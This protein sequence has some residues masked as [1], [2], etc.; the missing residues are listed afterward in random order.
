MKTKYAMVLLAMGV[1]AAAV[2]QENDDMYFNSKDRLKSN[3]AI[4]VVAAKRYQQEDVNA[5]RTN[6]INASDSYSGRGVNP[7]YNSQIKS[8]TS[9]IQNQPDYFVA[10]YQPVNV[11]SNLYNGGNTGYSNYYG[12]NSAYSNPYYNNMGY[13][14]FGSPYG[15]NNMYSSMYSPY[16]SMYGGMYSPYS[17]FGNSFGLRFGMG[18]YYG[19]GL[20]G[21]MGYGNMFGMY[22]PYSMYGYG[23][24]YGG[25]YGY[26][27][28]PVIIN[29]GGDYVNNNVIGKHGSR[30]SGLNNDYVSTTS[31]GGNSA[32]GRSGGTNSGSRTSSGTQAGTNYYDRSW[33]NNSSNMTR[34]NGGVD[35]SA[36]TGRTSTW[37]NTNRGS[38][39]NGNGGRSNSNWSNGG[40]S[41]T[42]S[43]GN[44]NS[45]FSNGSSS[46]GGS[47]GGGGFGGGGG[48]SSSGGGGGHSRGRN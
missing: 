4:E 45:G 30:S 10:N 13:G 39:D 25:G 38:F 20:Y 48:G 16:S 2:G 27:G 31:R 15:Y 5:V 32:A 36:G 8:G 12:N 24:Y 1:S 47:R 6:P 22:N 29:G 3:Q 35:N 34:S 18:S 33:R 9:V 37:G 21:G 46:F 43:F 17:S 11:N 44:G 42:S 7:E 14:G 26:S 28:Y 40:G 41:R 19:S 23:G